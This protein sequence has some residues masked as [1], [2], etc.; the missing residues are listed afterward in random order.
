MR[1]WELRKK[2]GNKGLNEK[3]TNKREDREKESEE[4][5]LSEVGE[6]KNDVERQK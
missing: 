2:D 3:I 6:N 5:C 1:E 4:K